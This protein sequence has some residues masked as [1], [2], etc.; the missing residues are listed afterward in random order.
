M[1]GPGSRAL[2]VVTVIAMLAAACTNG[3]RPDAD[4]GLPGSD[5]VHA[6]RAADDGALLLGLHGALWRSADGTSWESL[7]LE[8]HDAMAL[9]V[10]Q[11]G[12]PLLVGGHDVLARST[13]GGASFEMLAPSQLPSLDVHALAQAPSDPEI[14]YAYVVG[15]GIY[16]SA[17]AGDTWEPAAAVGGQLP[18]DLAAM[19]VDPRDAD[20]VL[21]GSGGHGVWRSTDAADSFAPANASGTLGL[22][23]AADGTVLAATN[24]GVEVSTDGG[25]SW[26]TVAAGGDLEGQP[27]AVAVQPDGTWWVITEQPRVLYHRDGEDAGFEE[28]ARA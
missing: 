23:F 12:A 25:T 11:D 28:V 18:G 24:Q 17:D 7:G 15:H 6:V 4:G 22:A 16:R 9:G 20:V 13:D 3:D 21:V 19:A 27:I 2:V 1:G 26:E 14:V 10:A 5:H 8:G